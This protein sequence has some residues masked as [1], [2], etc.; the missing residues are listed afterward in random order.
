MRSIG[1]LIKTRKMNREQWRKVYGAFRARRLAA[2][3]SAAL[4]RQAPGMFA[5]DAIGAR[6]VARVA[7]HPYV[8]RWG[9]GQW[10]ILGCR[11]NEPGWYWPVN[12]VGHSIAYPAPDWRSYSKSRGLLPL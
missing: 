5:F 2:E 7:P 11:K 8:S 9:N 3:A 6:F 4:R 12:I 1:K 10:N